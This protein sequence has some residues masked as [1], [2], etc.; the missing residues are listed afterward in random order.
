[1]RRP[2]NSLR[3][4]WTA[5]THRRTIV[6]RRPT[7]QRLHLEQLES[8]LAP[9]VSLLNHFDG[10]NFNVN[11]PH[12]APP[13]TCGAAGPNSYVETVNAAVTIYNKS[14]NAVIASDNLYDF[15]YN[16]GGIK[17][18]GGARTMRLWSTMSPSAG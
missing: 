17:P 14:T 13:D 5:P 1:M 6:R 3:R 9:A 16:K 15:L 4:F 10:M 8:R 12:G 18:V 11:T 2:W 7:G